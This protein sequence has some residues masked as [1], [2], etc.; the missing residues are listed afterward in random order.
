MTNPYQLS[1]QLLAL[2]P[3]RRRVRYLCNGTLAGVRNWLWCGSDWK[4]QGRKLRLRN[5]FTRN[6]FKLGNILVG[7]RANRA[8]VRLHIDV[9]RDFM[10]DNLRC[11]WLRHRYSRM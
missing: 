1:T 4:D 2:A 9:L 7:F 3:P 6:V 8:P 10:A 11:E 5:P